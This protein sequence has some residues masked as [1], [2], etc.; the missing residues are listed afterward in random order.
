MKYYA[1]AC[2]VR[3]L[4]RC[5][6]LLRSRVH[7]RNGAS[8]LWRTR[9]RAS[10]AARCVGRRW[11]RFERPSR[12]RPRRPRVGAGRPPAHAARVGR[13]G[14]RPELG[15]RKTTNG[16]RWAR[17]RRRAPRSL[18]GGAAAAIPG[19]A[20]GVGA[21]DGARAG[22]G[23]KPFKKG[24]AAKGLPDR[25][26]ALLEDERDDGDAT[27]TTTKKAF[28][29][30][31]ASSSSSDERTKRGMTND[32]ASSDDDSKAALRSSRPPPI[33]LAANATVAD[34]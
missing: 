19:G 5:V 29:N 8:L 17:A 27:E 12:R 1:W 6:K 3:V 11:R 34:R 7:D 20:R 18:A 33:E 14:H 21:A 25:F 9:P 32:K 26:A 16:G 23:K 2:G 13:G 22:T 10:F 15:S 31:A 30:R 4:L 28:P 24:T